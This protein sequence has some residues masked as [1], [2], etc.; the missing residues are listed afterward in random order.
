MIMMTDISSTDLQGSVTSQA[1]QQVVEVVECRAKRVATAICV[2]V[3]PIQ[4]SRSLCK[5]AA[6][7]A[8]ASKLTYQLNL[9]SR[10]L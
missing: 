6:S 4:K 9:Q 5:A 7:A 8:S 1:D 2:R 10:N 3:F